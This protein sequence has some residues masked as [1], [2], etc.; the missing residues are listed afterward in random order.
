MKTGILGGTFDPPH[1]GHLAIA[2]AALGQIQLDEVLF[3]PAN[4]NPLKPGR[5]IAS[6]A[7]RLEMLRLML[8]G[9]PNLALCDLEVTRGGPSYMVDTLTELQMV[10]PA[11]YWL[12]IGADALQ[13]FPKWKQPD[14]IIRLCRLG[15]VPRGI[16]TREEMLGWLPVELRNAVDFIDFPLQAVSSTDLR[17]KLAR[18]QP[19]SNWITREVKQYIDHHNLYRM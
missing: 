6:S 16:H 3:M 5:T 12:L 19:V 1:K 8:K 18:N 7:D 14:K 17:E 11:D 2:E 15:V 9:R 4:R 13:T 10:R